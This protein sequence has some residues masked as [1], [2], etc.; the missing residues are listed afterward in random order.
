MTPREIDELVAT[1]VMGQTRVSD[2]ALGD[3]RC[4]GHYSPMVR[5]PCLPL[6]S[7]DIAAAWHVLERL[8]ETY[9]ITLELDIGP[10]YEEFPP[11][12]PVPLSAIRYGITLRE[13]YLTTNP[14]NMWD[15]AS[16]PMAICLA[17]LKAYGVDV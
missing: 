9:S 13:H 16:A 17:A 14:G 12:P 15:V 5:G 2:C 11:Y 10:H 7:T 3:E 1:K 4:P 6:Y 8:A